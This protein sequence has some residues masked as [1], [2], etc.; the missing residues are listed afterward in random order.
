MAVKLE[1]ILKR[2]NSDLRTFI[3]KNKLT[4]YKMLL[5]YCK[6][7]KFSPCTEKEFK[8]SLPIS[9]VSVK[10]KDE[11]KSDRVEKSVG[12]KTSPTQKKEKS[13]SRTKS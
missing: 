7:R 2:N 1:Y 4:S 11:Q 10:K 12:R 8:D 13:R 9:K 5:E 6:Q 3:V